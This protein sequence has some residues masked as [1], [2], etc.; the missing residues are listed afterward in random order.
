MIARLRLT[1]L[2]ACLSLAAGAALAAT[3]T[4]YDYDALG[5]LT[6]VTTSDGKV[7]TY[8]YDAAGNRTQVASGTEAGV[9]SSISVPMSGTTATY[10][11]SWGS[12]TGTVTAYELY[13]ATNSSF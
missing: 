1:G 8:Q 4:T 6:G 2:L 10:T 9:P 13:E 7:V 11:V 5:R 12:A 3:T